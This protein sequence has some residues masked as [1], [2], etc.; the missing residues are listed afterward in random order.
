MAQQLSVL[1]ASRP[2]TIG[3]VLQQHLAEEQMTQLQQAFGAVSEESCEDVMWPFTDV[4]YLLS[5]PVFRWCEQEGREL[6]YKRQSRREVLIRILG[7]HGHTHTPYIYTK[8]R[9][10]FIIETISGPHHT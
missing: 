4:P 1:A 2:G 7:Q 9:G 10:N 3:P 6:K 8:S 5:R